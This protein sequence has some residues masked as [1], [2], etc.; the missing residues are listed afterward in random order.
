LG[1]NLYL[2]YIFVTLRLMF[3]MVGG[4][5]SKNQGIGGRREIP[6]SGIGNRWGI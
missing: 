5:E 3:L 4:G 2:R 6:S 1:E